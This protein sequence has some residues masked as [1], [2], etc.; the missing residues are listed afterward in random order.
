[1]AGGAET[2]SVAEQSMRKLLALSEPPDAVFCYNDAM[3]AACLRVSMSVGIKVPEEIAFVGVGN[4][5]FSD[6]LWS[7]L[8]TIEQHAGR[9]GE[10]AA[11]NLLKAIDTHTE[12]GIEYVQGD[13]IVRESCGTRRFTPHA[14]A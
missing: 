8:T 6:V 12:T 7:P 5:R 3:A 13:L 4:T 11:T 14:V 9:I 10:V 1:M 2:D